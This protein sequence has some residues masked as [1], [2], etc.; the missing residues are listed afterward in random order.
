MSFN[1]DAYKFQVSVDENEDTEWND[2]LRE[3][4]IIPQK[5]KWKM[6]KWKKRLTIW[7]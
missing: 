4:G 6:K 5:K 2:I 3:H 1:P 7:F